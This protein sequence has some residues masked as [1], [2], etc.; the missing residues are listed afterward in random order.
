M[1]HFPEHSL[2]VTP[3]V[4]PMVMAANIGLPVLLLGVLAVVAVV[5]GLGMVFGRGARRGT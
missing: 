4:D 3:T 2:L 1:R 5:Y